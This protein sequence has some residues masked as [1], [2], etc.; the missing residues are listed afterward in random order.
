M[1]TRSQID[2]KFAA[3]A[4]KAEALTPG[5]A[6]A[7]GA[8]DDE[9]TARRRRERV[10]HEADPYL[11]EEDL[12]EVAQADL[13]KAFNQ[14][15]DTPAGYPSMRTVNAEQFRRGPIADGEAAYSP[16]YSQPGRAVPVPSATL[17]PGMA[18]R[19]LLA[20]GRSRACVPGA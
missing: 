16:A 1:L 17:A 20:E 6:A 9:E 19:P 2:K 10:Q 5:H 15:F 13:P 14:A 11:H 18:T 4:L 3:R 12:P 8:M 7:E